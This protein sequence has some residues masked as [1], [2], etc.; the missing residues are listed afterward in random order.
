[1]DPANRLTC[2]TC[3]GPVAPGFARC[4]Q[5]DLANSQ[6]GGLLADV[7]VPVGYAVKGG[8]LAADLRR[9]KSGRDGA[10]A[11]AARLASL[12]SAFLQGHG[13]CVWRAA[14][15]SAPP[16]AAAVVPSGQGRPG[17]HPLLGIVRACVDLPIVALTTGPPGT[18]RSRGVSIGWLR[19]AG[20][21]ATDG[22]LLVDDCWV[23]GGS[24][25]SAAAALKLAGARRVALVVL[26]RHVDP[27][28]PRSAELVRALRSSPPACPCGA[29]ASLRAG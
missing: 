5:C 1:M 20:R 19:A 3:R 6:A 13:D 24:A 29:G 28:D 27:G 12:L 21:L 10:S 4:Y 14:G 9:Y 25:Q 11:A 2:R 16:A 17:T 7:V 26:G 18:A 15:M 23:S 8:Q 22:V